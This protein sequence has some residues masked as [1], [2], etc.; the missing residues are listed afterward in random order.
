RHRWWPGATSPASRQ[1]QRRPV[2]GPLCPTRGF[3]DQGRQACGLVSTQS[4]LEEINAMSGMPLADKVGLVIGVAN[5]RS[6]AW[7]IAERADALGAAQVL[8][9]PNDRLAENVRDLGAQLRTPMLLPCDVT[10]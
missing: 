6:I 10:S 8:T 4:F 7:A 2:V 3:R 5:K 1:A 9:Y